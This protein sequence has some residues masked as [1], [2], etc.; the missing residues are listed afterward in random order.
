MLKECEKFPKKAEVY[1][2]ESIPLLLFC[3]QISAIQYE[4]ETFRP[5]NLKQNLHYW[6]SKSA[7]TRFEWPTKVDYYRH[8]HEAHNWRTN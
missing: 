4:R 7:K 5:L 8:T 2:Q 3:Q 6:R 1:E